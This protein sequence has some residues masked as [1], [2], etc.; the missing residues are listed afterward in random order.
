MVPGPTVGEAGGMTSQPL[1]YRRHR[2]PA[3]IIRHAVWLYHV[4]S[5][6]LRGG[7]AKPPRWQNLFRMEQSGAPLK[8]TERRQS[9]ADRRSRSAARPFSSIIA[10]SESFPV[11]PRR[12]REGAEARCPI[13]AKLSIQ[14][15]GRISCCSCGS[16]SCGSVRANAEWQGRFRGGSQIWRISTRPA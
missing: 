4:F 11:T 15:P 9:A 1:S 2:F 16:C 8:S 12:R 3:A 10:S 14:R 5:L 6:S 13:R 7:R